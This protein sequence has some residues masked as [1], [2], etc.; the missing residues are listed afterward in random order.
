[1]NPSVELKNAMLRFIESFSSG[2]VST[3]EHLFSHQDGVLALGTDPSEWWAGYDTITRVFKAQLQEMGGNV[4]LKV[5]ELDAFVEGT[6]GW[7]ASSARWQLP[8]GQEIPIRLTAVFHQEDKEWKIV[9]N[10]ASIGVPNT[11]TL[12]KELTIK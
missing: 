8:K 4:K 7:A 10:H 12:G 5:G 9:Q 6:V 1:M 11:E 3:I 2:D